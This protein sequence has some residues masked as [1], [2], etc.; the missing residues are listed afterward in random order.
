M[1]ID[2]LIFKPA[3]PHADKEGCP[4]AIAY[5][6]D[7]QKL[8]NFALAGVARWPSPSMSSTGGSLFNPGVPE[9]RYDPQKANDMLDKAGVVRGA[10][11]TRFKMRL[12]YSGR[13]SDVMVAEV[14]R[15]S[16]RQIGID[17]QLV[18][19]DLATF[20][21]S[22]F[23]QWDFDSAIQM[24]ATA[25]IPRGLSKWFHS[26]MIK[27]TRNSNVM[28]YINPEVDKL[29]DA[30]FTQ[31]DLK[32][33]AEMWHR[34]QAIILDDLPLLPLHEIPVLTAYRSGG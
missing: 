13:G 22:L 9:Y 4:A 1:A 14:I 16:L 27:K 18:S 8:F 24:S 29:L 21:D 17:V 33:R 6:I 30:E 32:K 15:D 11:G 19:L 25:L 23:Q 3:S 10:D 26:K 34:I 5:G 2:F 7:K 28:G 31:V 12:T 20:Y